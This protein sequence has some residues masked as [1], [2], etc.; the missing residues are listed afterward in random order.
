VIARVQAG[1][2]ALRRATSAL[3]ELLARNT[4]LMRQDRDLTGRVAELTAAIDARLGG[5][6]GD[7]RS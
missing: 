3:R 1:E 6:A 7:D 4:E 5:P 2:E